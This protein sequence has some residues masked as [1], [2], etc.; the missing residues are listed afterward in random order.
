VSWGEVEKTIADFNVAYHEW[1]ATTEVAG[2][3]AHQA[4]YA[5]F[6]TAH[7]A[8]KQALARQWDPVLDG[9]RADD[10]NLP[11]LGRTLQRYYAEN[12]LEGKV[13]R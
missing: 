7:E 13:K 9:Y 6:I 2:S 4:V 1:L 8:R 12:Q 10:E 11:S 3:K 5:A